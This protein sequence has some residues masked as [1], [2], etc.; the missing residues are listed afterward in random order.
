MGSRKNEKS[1]PRIAITTLAG[2]L[3]GMLIIRIFLIT[4]ITAGPSM[5]PAFPEGTRLLVFKLSEPIVGDVIIARNPLSQGT[6]LCSRVAAKDEASVEIRNKVVYING[7]KF[8]PA[9]LQEKDLRNFPNS[10]TK[11]DNMPLLRLKHD[12]YF[13]LGDNRDQ[14]FDSRYFG[15]LHEK[16]IIGKVIY[17]F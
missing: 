2:F 3:S 15:A 9:G 7:K 8:A 5:S 4:M 17:T 12:E 6:V 10:F 16:D 13:I 11:R 14:S 1:I